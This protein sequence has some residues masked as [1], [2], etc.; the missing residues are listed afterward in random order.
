[1]KT[2]A[3]RLVGP[4]KLDMVELDVPDPSPG[5]VKHDLKRATADGPVRRSP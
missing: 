2:E 1:M 3:L 4:G 5:E